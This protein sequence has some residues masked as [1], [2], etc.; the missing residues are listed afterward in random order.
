MVV[1]RSAPRGEAGL[2]VSR[3][4]PAGRLTKASHT[5]GTKLTTH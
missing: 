5:F 3:Q 4:G 1:S 2:D